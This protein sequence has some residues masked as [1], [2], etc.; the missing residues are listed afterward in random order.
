MTGCPPWRLLSRQ[1][2]PA[3]ETLPSVKLGVMPRV[4]KLPIDS[5]FPVC[6]AGL[7]DQAGGECVAYSQAFCDLLP[8]Q[9]SEQHG[10]RL[11]PSQPSSF[12]HATTAD[13]GWL[14]IKY[15]QPPAADAWGKRALLILAHA[16][17]LLVLVGP[18]RLELSPFR[19]GT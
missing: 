9:S 14:G 11:F 12:L 4:F 10:E 1:F 19:T 16:L 17:S 6:L 18:E 2:V 7:P 3:N 15:S 8:A 13:P 5:N